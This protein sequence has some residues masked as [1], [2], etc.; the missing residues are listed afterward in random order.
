MTL[1]AAY[2]KHCSM[3]R[4][5][6]DELQIR[7]LAHFQKVLDDLAKQNSC[8]GRLWYRNV[9]GIYLY[10]PVGTGKTYL[11]DLF[12]EAAPVT[13]KARLHFHH[14]MQ[15]V[16]AQLRRLQGQAD[17]IRQIA[18]QIAAQSKLLCLDEFLVKDVAHAM[19]LKELLQTLLDA[20]VVLVT[21]ANTKPDHL[22]QHGVHRERF[23]PAINLLKQRCE[24]LEIVSNQ[25]Y[26]LGREHAPQSYLFPCN[27]KNLKLFE[28]QFNN[29]GQQQANA[30]LLTIQ[31]RP[32]QAVAVLPGVVW[33]EFKVIC[34]MPRCQ[35]DYLE[36]AERF[37]TVFLSQVPA[38]A[39]DD[40]AQVILF[41][42]LIDVLYDR[43]IRLFMLADVAIQQLYQQG[44]MLKEFNRTQSR[45][46]EMQSS[47]YL[48]KEPNCETRFN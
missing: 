2:E 5:K 34:Q 27:Q 15:Q 23:V 42:H 16:D 22:Y 46:E 37:H 39:A 31:H 8:L 3:G 24:V 45:L 35:L 28:L 14:F 25:D 32:I 38:L 6:R 41:I 9:R 19:I 4:V 44:P 43:G 21:T 47:Y 11:M 18:K 33:F 26:R 36:L 10:G 7:L 17:P 20:G 48:N 29:M 30:S 13:G 12:Y 1:Q 40:M